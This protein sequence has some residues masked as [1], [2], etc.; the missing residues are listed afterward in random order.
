MND[1]RQNPFFFSFYG[2]LFLVINSIVFLFLCAVVF[3][4]LCVV[5]NDLYN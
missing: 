2:C 4:I 3:S 5:G 1:W